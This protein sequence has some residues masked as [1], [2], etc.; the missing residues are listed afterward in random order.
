MAV[1]KAAPANTAGTDGDYEFLQMSAGRLWCS[2]TID[3]ALPAGTNGIGKLTS[4]SGVTIG[5]VEIAAAQTLATVTTVSTVTT[6]STVTALT[7]GGVAHDGVDSGNPH[8]IGGRAIAHGANPTA[9]AAADRTDWLFNRAGVPFTIGGHPN[10]QTVSARIED[11]DGALTDQ[12]LVTVA[13]GL[14]I[15]VTRLSITADGSNT[16]PYNVTVGFGAA[17]VPAHAH[18]GTAGILQDFAGVPAGGGITVGNGSGIIGVGADGEDL[19][20]TV[21]DPAGGNLTITVSYFTIDS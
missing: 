1:Q 8:K 7:G 5:A 16:G 2:T 9:V 6:C 14:K 3:A 12:A 18:T 17:N 15:V 20:Y 11:A 4:N 21:E 19:R 10:T 13:G